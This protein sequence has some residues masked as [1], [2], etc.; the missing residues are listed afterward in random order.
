MRVHQ[1]QNTPRMN[2]GTFQFRGAKTKDGSYSFVRMC[3]ISLQT[4]NM[5]QMI[6]S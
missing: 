2:D 5:V 3:F 1:T 6:H 4:L